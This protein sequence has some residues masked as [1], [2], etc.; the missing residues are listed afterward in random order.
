MIVPL[1]WLKE[2][3]D[4]DVTPQE[5]ET[6][7][8]DCGFEVETLTELGAEVSGVV[9]GLV[10]HC[11]PIPDTHLHVCQVDCGEHGKFQIC[12]GAD[13]VKAGGKYPA[14]LVGAQVYATAKDHVTIEGTMKIKKGKLKGFESQGMLC[15]GIE[16]GL[17]DDLYP[18]A[19][20]CGLLVLPE[21]AP[22]GADI[23]PL[24][25]LDDWMYDISITANRPDCM[26]VLGI[27]REVAAALGK[28]LKMP[29][30]DYKTDG[31]K[32]D[33]FKVTV[34]DTDLC[35]RY[36]AHYVRNV[37]IAQSPAW[38][39]RRLAL[40]GIR[41]ISNIVDIT[42][43]VLKEIGQPMHAFDLRQLEEKQIVVRR[44]KQDETI[45]TLDEKEFKLNPNNLVICDGKKPVALAGIMGGLNSEIKDDTA[46]VVF[47]SAKF[48]RDN[49]R[50]TSRA[51]GQHSDSS[52]RF[53]KGVDEYATQLGLKRALHL[54]DELGCGSVTESGFA[55]SV[56][57]DPTATRPLTVSIAKI[58]ALLG[59][60]VPDDEIIRILTNLD[61]APQISGDAL[62]VQVPPYR[63]DIENAPDIAEELIRMYGYQHITPTFLAAASVTNGGRNAAQNSLL[64]LKR[65]LAAQGLCEAIHYSFYSPKD[66]DLLRIPQDAP[67]R[68]AI[69]ILNPIS[70]DLSIMRTMLAPSMLNAVIRNVRRGNDEGGLFEIAKTYHS[71][72]EHPSE[73]PEEREALSIGLFDGGKLSFFDGKAVLEALA[74]AFRLSFTYKKPENPEKYPFLHPGMSAVV[75]LDGQEI[76]WIGMLAHDLTDA[77]VPEHAVLLAELDLTALRPYLCK[78]VTFEMLPKFPVVQ[79]DIALLVSEKV[80]CADLEA[81]MKRSCKSL[82]QVRLF[83]VY[84]GKQIEAGKQSLAF[85]L[86]FRS[87]D[88][89]LTDQEVDQFVAKILKNLGKEFEAT[90]R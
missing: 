58:N 84:K 20:Y 39:R 23:K 56:S 34:E 8:F 53:E 16:I 18:G 10:E 15:S 69:R 64:K 85:S 86:W 41:S 59:I 28:L 37:K 80:I 7:L 12:C 70:E 68:Q 67:Q 77:E 47:E 31:T 81:C 73:E 30:L 14:A 83:D 4:I 61:F 76:G 6:K 75:S 51:L 11:E 13:N 48:M 82:N 89:A 33:G 19:E 2:Y 43:Y 60:T 29:A 66:L 54:I 1:S 72:E 44:A 50:K 26:S 74:A 5:L 17:N 9:V 32:L 52:Q 45:V 38:M 22:V 25:G 71:A 65:T 78:P 63:E 87:D 24:V 35:P 21:D 88:H 55:E 57:A 36:Q 79:R 40:V 46:D 3:V 49:V 62:S 90:Q 42:N 27:A